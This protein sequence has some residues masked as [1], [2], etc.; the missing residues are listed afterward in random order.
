MS[1]ARTAGYRAL[2]GA[3]GVVA[4]LRRFTSVLTYPPSSTSTAAADSQVRQ[5][6]ACPRI[7]DVKNTCLRVSGS[8]HRPSP[9]RRQAPLNA[10]G[11][12]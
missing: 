3:A 12:T 1:E 7:L 9:I 4:A 5:A 11:I 6:I 8:S 2:A 10:T